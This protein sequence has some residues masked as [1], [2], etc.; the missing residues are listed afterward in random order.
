MPL[1]LRVHTE[2][3]V[4]QLDKD[5]D[6]A[7]VEPDK[8]P[9]LVPAP[10]QEDVLKHGNHDQ[11]THG[12][13]ATGELH[14]GSGYKDSDEHPKYDYDTMDGTYLEAYCGPYSNDIN[15]FLRTGEYGDYDLEEEMPD[16]LDAMD[17]LI[18]QTETPREMALYRGIGGEG[19]DTFAGMKVGD[20]Y[21]DKGYVSTTPNPDQLWEFLPA[22]NGGYKG[23]VLE[24]TVPKGTQLLS[25]K[26][27]FEGVSKSFA[28][29]DSILDE[30]EHILPR[31]LK[32]K[33]TGIGETRVSSNS[34]REGN[35]PDLL[36]QVEVVG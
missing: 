14:E 12:S 19:Y 3:R 25:V 35:P 10:Y 7:I 31:G 28:P 6:Y 34:Q 36:I 22:N 8:D 9:A 24:I 33:V 16:Y 17:N 26:K 23:T 11:K 21:T 20:V 2:R 27:Y 5:F 13:W 32:F 30:N 4:S 15:G 18:S 1:V 29:A